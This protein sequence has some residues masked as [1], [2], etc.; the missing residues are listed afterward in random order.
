MMVNV[1]LPGMTMNASVLKAGKVE[2]VRSWNTGDCA[3]ST[4]NLAASTRT[5]G[6]DGEFFDFKTISI[7]HFQ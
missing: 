6:Q 4:L 3:T 1:M 5:T 2:I 7:H